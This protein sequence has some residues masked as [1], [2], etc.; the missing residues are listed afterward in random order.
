M[1][2]RVFS[3]LMVVLLF[4]MPCLTLAQQTNDAAQAIVDA[5]RDAKNPQNGYIWFPAGCLLGV[6]GLGVVGILLAA[7]YS[8][9]PPATRLLGKSPEYIVYYTETYQN[10]AK[11]DQMTEATLGCLLGSCLLS[12]AYARVISQNPNLFYTY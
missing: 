1:L 6:V 9:P 7:V 12:L 4:S 8:P 10:V 11:D 2:F 3:C 5:T